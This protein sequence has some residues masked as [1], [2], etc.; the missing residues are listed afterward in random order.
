MD[1][2]SFVITFCIIFFIY[3]VLRRP[4]SL[5]LA[6]IL[7]VIFVFIFVPIQF[8]QEWFR[9]FKP[10]NYILSNPIPGISTYREGFLDSFEDYGHYLKGRMSKEK[11][12]KFIKASEYKKYDGKTG[13]PIFWD[14]DQNDSGTMEP[15][16][17]PSPSLDNTYYIIFS[18]DDFSGVM[19]KYEDGFVYMKSW[20]Y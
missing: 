17:D 19:F 6:I 16:W 15:W 13:S 14:W 20:K 12:D 3:L 5:G 2:I 8:S 18:E 10:A 7:S 11:F 4:L 1:L 9:E